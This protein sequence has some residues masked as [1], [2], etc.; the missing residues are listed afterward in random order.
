MAQALG[1]SVALG[2]LGLCWSLAIAHPLPP[3][4]APGN[5]AEGGNGV[6]LDPDVLER[7]S[8]GWSF[9]ATTLDEHGA[10]LFFKGEFVWKS[11]NWT[12]ELISERWKNFNSTVDAAFRHSHD[13]IFLIK[14]DKVWVYPPEKKDKGYPKLLQEEF[15]G[16][17]FPLDAAVE[18]HRGECQDEGILFFKGNRTWFWDFTTG[19]EKER[20]WP[21]VGDCSS[22][23]RW[24]GRY[25]CFRGNQFLHFNPV[26]GE[27]NS[28]YPLDVRD[29]FM[30]CPGHGHRNR[31]SHWNTTHHGHW[32]VPCGTDIALSALLSDN[33]GAIY[34][35]I[36]SHYWRLD[37]SRDGWHR[38]PIGHQWPQGPS[39]VDAAF[40]WEDKL[41]LI[42]GT[43]VYIFLTKGGY[44]LVDGYP[45]QLEKELGSPPGISL[46]AVDA[47]FTCPGSSR[48]H[49]MAGRRLWWLDLQSRAP[50][51]WTELPWPHEKVDA[52]LCVDKSLGPHSCSANGLGLYL[53]QGSNL[54]CF[55]DLE[56]LNAAKTLPQPQRVNSLLGC[57]H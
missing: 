17:P 12:R 56:K 7:C 33:H 35:F 26:S 3:A 49:V 10:M 16:I 23:M 8:D 36:G 46:R 34:A 21:A 39:T 22:A 44:T 29:Y 2:L 20:F 6:K 27:V 37:T 45:K 18:C 4:S 9:D 50:A 11:H 28:K 31:T 57:N 14:G 30:P 13:S 25:Y 48:L 43:Q 32:D 1:E 53:I 24:I 42:Q 15:P 40:S 47:A 52:A 41:Y 54:Y 51:T 38:W 19:T 5:G 55:S